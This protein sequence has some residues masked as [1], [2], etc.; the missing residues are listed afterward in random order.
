MNIIR[1]YWEEIVIIVLFF[2]FA[3]LFYG[4][5]PPP[6]PDEPF[7][8]EL[9]DNLANNGIFG[10]DFYGKA[11]GGQVEATLGIPPLF[12]IIMTP[13]FWIF[14][15]SLELLR[16]T[17][18]SFAVVALSMAAVIL[19][20]LIS[21]RWIAAAT[22][23]LIAFHPYFVRGARIGRYE[24]FALMLV[25]FAAY[26]FIK[27]QAQTMNGES[28]LKYLL[29]SSVFTGLLGITH[30]V[31]VFIYIAVL[32][33]LIVSNRFAKFIRLS[34]LYSI[35]PL[36]IFS[37]WAVY[38]LL[39]FDLFMAQMGT[40]V[41]RK[42]G[43][44]LMLAGIKAHY[45]VIPVVIIFFIAALCFA[46]AN[47]IKDF[48]RMF[49]CFIAAYAGL[50]YVVWSEMW[51]IVYPLTFLIMSAGVV[52]DL[53]LKSRSVVLKYASLV[54]IPIFLLLGW[55]EYSKNMKEHSL[56]KMSF[57]EFCAELRVNELPE[58]SKIY[59]AGIPDPY[60]CF[61][62]VNKYKILGYMGVGATPDV[63]LMYKEIAES[64][65]FFLGFEPSSMFLI[66]RGFDREL[67]PMRQ[68]YFSSKYKVTLY[69]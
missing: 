35:I 41:A 4:Q 1:Y 15:P 49:I 64:D 46:K 50:I 29:I 8:L 42:Q 67:I 31:N 16:F 39:N 5:Y 17:S 7:Y 57:D 36:I 22:L 13:L 3:V 18:I 68:G 20:K 47:R 24:M 27:Y 48:R 61:D 59:L 65:Y 55:N 56:S 38:I 14:K 60:F 10:T 23:A 21:R 52:F 62:D 11:A 25:M 43:L 19:R 28:G 45:I 32:S 33:A 58:G 54:F 6:W 26:F 34:L 30:P 53:G 63:Q 37:F 51:Y 66:D 2:I 44:F 12:F 40:G 69:R 9:I